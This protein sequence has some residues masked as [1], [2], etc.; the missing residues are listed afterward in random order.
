MKVTLKFLEGMHFV[1]SARQ[2]KNIHLDEPKSFHGT[3]L[4]PS[5]VEYFLIGTGGCIG[6]TFVYCL[7]KNNIEIDKLEVVIDGQ[8]KHVGPKMHLRLVKIDV[9]LLITIKEG[10]SFEKMDLCQKMFQEYCP[11][12]N[13][14]IQGI[15]LNTKVSKI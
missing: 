11:I 1:A 10:E 8:L 15:P 14:L 12:S 3:D 5:S 6:S 4:A 13:V 2:F 9:E 7:Q